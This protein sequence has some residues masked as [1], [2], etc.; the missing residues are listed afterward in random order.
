[1]DTLARGLGYIDVNFMGFPRVIATAVLQGPGGVALIDPGPSTS[2]D[3]LRA[4]LE[5]H[6]MTVADVR[7]VLLTHIHLDHAGA[8]GS[9]VRENPKIAVYVHEK[10]APHMV[11]PEKLLASAARLYGD[12][13]GTLW[14]EFAPIPEANIR[15]LAGGERIDVSDRQLDV[16]YIPGHAS[17]HVGYF[18]SASGVAF[19][20][21]TAGIRLGTELF[22]TPPTPPPDIDVEAWVESVELIRRRHPSTLFVTHFGPHEDVSAHLDAFLEHLAAAKDLARTIVESDATDE[23]KASEFT[24]QMRLYIQRFMP[25]QQTDLFDGAPLGPLSLGWLGLRRYWRK[26]GVEG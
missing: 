2:L 11:S 8:T 16:V 18:D 13:M 4:S 22:A 1:M 14:G 20:G 12:Q 17:H 9:L 25:A 21:D 6:G 19:V 7:A 3:T 5:E 26:Q 23:D 24:H 10:G 15:S